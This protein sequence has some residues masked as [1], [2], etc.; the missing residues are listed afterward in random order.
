MTPCANSRTDVLK[1]LRRMSSSF[2]IPSAAS[3]FD[4]TASWHTP[5]RRI[6]RFRYGRADRG[7]RA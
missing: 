2:S 5:I 7:R 6:K 4:S 1:L 3:A